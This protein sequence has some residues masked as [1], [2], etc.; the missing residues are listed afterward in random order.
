VSVEGWFTSEDLVL[1]PGATASIPLTVHNL[2]RTTESYTIVPAGLNAAWTAVGDGNLTLFAGS[3]QTVAVTVSPPALPTTA[4][5]PTV[6]AVR[7]TS[8]SDPDASMVAETTIG[9]AAFDDRRVVPLNPVVRAR[10]RA[11]FELMVENQGNALAS[12]RLRLVDPSNR[13]DGDFDPPA[14]GVPPG[15]STLVQLRARAVGRRFRRA[16]RTLE[17]EVEAEQPGHAPAAAPFAL[18]RSPTISGSTVG[19][20]LAALVLVGGLVG[21][22]FGVIEPAL[23]DAAEQRVDERIGELLAAQ[24]TPTVPADADGSASPDT[25]EEDEPDPARRCTSGWS[26]TPASDRPPTRPTPCRPPTSSTS[27]TYGSRIP[28]A[29]TVSP[30]CWSTANRCSSGRCRTSASVCSSRG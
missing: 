10:R 23:D 17:F 12:C 2:G 21:A 25:A 6:I 28:P 27:P 24:P 11:T 19:R 14:V 13:V 7:I 1:Q 22:W 15:G 16:T 30:R 3:R 29:T 26:S 5:G 18:L 8:E 20:W 4:A 9:V